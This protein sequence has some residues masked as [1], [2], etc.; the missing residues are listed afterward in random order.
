MAKNT[1]PDEEELKE[2]E[3]EEGVQGGEDDGDGEEEIENDS[4]KE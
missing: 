4:K 3:G 2:P 1:K